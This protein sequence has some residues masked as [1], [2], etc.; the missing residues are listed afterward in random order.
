MISLPSALMR[1]FEERGPIDGPSVPTNA[2][3]C[4]WDRPE[5]FWIGGKL[6][7]YFPNILGVLADGAVGGEP[8][9]SCDVEHARARPIGGRQPQPLDSSLRCAIGIEIHCHHVVVRISQLV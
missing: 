3:L 5:S 8:R 6:K 9:H 2:A 1:Q 7:G 4:P